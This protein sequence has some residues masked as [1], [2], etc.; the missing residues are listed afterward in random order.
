MLAAIGATDV[1]SIQTEVSQQSGL[2]KITAVNFLASKMRRTI[3]A[4]S[5]FFLRQ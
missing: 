5:G 1:L 4:R 2:T 3:E